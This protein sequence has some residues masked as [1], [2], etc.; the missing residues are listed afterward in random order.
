MDTAPLSFTTHL[1][2][3]IAQM[4]VQDHLPSTIEQLQSYLRQAHEAGVQLL[5]LP[6]LWN[7]PYINERIRA[8]AF[9][10]QVLLPLI[11]KAA[12]EYGMY[13]VA[14]TLPV[15]ENGKLYNRAMVYDPGGVCIAKADKLH[16]LEVHTSKSDYCESDVFSPG[17]EIVSFQTPWGNVGLVICFDMRFCEIPRLLGERCFLLLGI[18][19]FNAAAG[20]KHWNPLMQTRAME[21]EVFLLA[22]NPAM[23]EYGAYRSYGHSL[24]AGPDGEI[25]M[26]LS[27]KPGLLV[28]D[29]P[30]EEVG[31]IR[32]RSPFW[33]LRRTDLFSLS[34]KSPAQPPADLA[35]Q[36]QAE[37]TKQEQETEQE[38]EQEKEQETE[39][40]AI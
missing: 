5:V 10:F 21:N 16:L 19:A 7:T 9:D 40:R 23:G 36:A 17:E 4:S 2:A 37:I 1:R 26:Q 8:H 33:Q 39:S 12:K 14:G 34:E 30:L 31:A 25:L 6:E 38:T 13:I 3:G 18:C 11:E 32:H 29:L 28:I 27:E 22:A 24:C 15:E 20:R 35:L